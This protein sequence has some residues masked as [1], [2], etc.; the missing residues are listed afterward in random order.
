M[1]GKL[2]YA[3]VEVH[4]QLGDASQPGGDKKRR[5]GDAVKREKKP[6]F[7]VALDLVPALQAKWGLNLSVKKVLLGSDLENC[8]S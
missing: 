2:Q 7:I 6:F 5:L 3:I 1:N 8:R 4:S